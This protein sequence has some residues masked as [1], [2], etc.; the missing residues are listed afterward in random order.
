MKKLLLMFVLLCGGTIIS[1][2]IERELITGKIIVEGN[3]IEGISIYNT[4]A[5][6]GAISDENGVFVIP[7]A[8]NDRLEIRALE[9]QDFDVTINEAIL[10]SKELKI[11]LIE[12]INLLSEI[13]IN[14]RKLTGN[15]NIDAKNIKT[16]SPKLDV[17]YFAINSNNAVDSKIENTAMTTQGNNLT[18]GLSLINI[19]D[20][21]L[22][23]LFRSEVEDKS[24]LGIPEIPAKSIKYYFG[25]D[26]ISENFNIPEYRVEE[27][28]RY[29]E[30]SSFDYDLLNYG[31]ELEFLELLNRK[32]KLFL[33]KQ[34]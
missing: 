22:I 13:V 15:L 24:S 18:N 26:F 1:Q 17:V 9:Y 20:Q 10:K 29:V 34:P 27:F 19:V 32:S 33:R 14:N 6:K 2:E 16:F 21:L 23:P 5:S 25:A 31:R 30:D 4:T 28:I 8:I 12:E 3:D 7:V 11:Y